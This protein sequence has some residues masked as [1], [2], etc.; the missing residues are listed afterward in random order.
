MIFRYLTWTRQLSQR[1]QSYEMVESDQ[2]EHFPASCTGKAGGIC[3]EVLWNPGKRDLKI[4]SKGATIWILRTVG[5][6]HK[7]RLARL[8]VLPLSLCQ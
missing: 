1:K 2:T 3:M 5:R 4:L 6:I 8:N 7:G